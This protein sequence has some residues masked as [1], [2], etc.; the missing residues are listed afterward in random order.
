MK[1]THTTSES[2]VRMFA[3]LLFQLGAIVDLCVISEF[4]ESKKI[5]RENCTEGQ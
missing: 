5:A 1:L 2:H 4:G 3:W